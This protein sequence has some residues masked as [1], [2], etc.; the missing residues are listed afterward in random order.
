MKLHANMPARVKR[1]EGK[2][3]DNYGFPLLSLLGVPATRAVD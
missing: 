2:N 1:L 3:A